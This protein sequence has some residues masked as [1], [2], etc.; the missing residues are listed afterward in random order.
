MSDKWKLRINWFGEI[1]ILIGLVGGC[2]FT[3]AYTP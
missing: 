2:A 1:C 3:V